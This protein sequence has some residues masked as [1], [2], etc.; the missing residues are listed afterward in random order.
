[1]PLLEKGRNRVNQCLRYYRMGS[2]KGRIELHSI[3]ASLAFPYLFQAADSVKVQRLNTNRGILSQ[4]TKENLT[5]EPKQLEDIEDF[6]QTFYIET[7]DL[8]R[9]AYQLSCNYQPQTLLE[10]SE[11]MAFTERYSQQ[12]PQ[13]SSSQ[14]TKARS[15]SASVPTKGKSLI[16]LRA[17]NFMARRA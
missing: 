9:N 5:L 13:R 16:A 8:F 6:L 2:R 15:P 17:Q 7:L 3:L 12:S 14:E 4:I 1:M 11:Y 10:L